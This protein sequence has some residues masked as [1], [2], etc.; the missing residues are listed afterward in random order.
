MLQQSL[1]KSAKAICLKL[2]IVKSEEELKKEIGH[3][4]L[5]K[6]PK[7]IVDNITEM[8]EQLL[9][10]IEPILILTN[11]KDGISVNFADELNKI[12]QELRQTIE[13]TFEEHQKKAKEFYGAIEE[14]AKKAFEK[15]DERSKKKID[16]Q[17]DRITIQKYSLFLP[18]TEGLKEAI[19]Q[20]LKIAEK[21]G[22][23]TSLSE[24]SILSMLHL[25][26]TLGMIMCWH[27]PFEGNINKLRYRL[28]DLNNDTVL[29]QWGQD[30][31]KQ[32]EKTDML[33]CLEE[34]TT[35]EIKSPICRKILDSLKEYIYG[36]KE[37]Q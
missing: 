32:I 28:L 36:L 15:V 25:A 27:T 5:K 4:I 24:D 7:L 37:S 31:V 14:V 16:E 34:F 19:I 20:Y 10:Y 22:R 9:R 17:I 33:T 8:F 26:T 35:A 29:V 18:L 13:E 11:L 2:C 1:E 12:I 6:I 23:P 3:S 30:I 21:Y